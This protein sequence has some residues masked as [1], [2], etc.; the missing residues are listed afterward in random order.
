MVKSKRKDY[1]AIIWLS[2]GV[3]SYYRSSSHH[4]AIEGVAKRFRNEFSREKGDEVI[5]NVVDVKGCGRVY[6]DD[7]FEYG[8]YTKSE[9]KLNLPI[10][11]VHYIY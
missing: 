5:I 4:K 2:S 10:Q 1:L 3:G 9:E 11:Y 7:D 8:F 6:W